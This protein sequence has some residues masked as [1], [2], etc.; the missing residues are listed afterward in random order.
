MSKKP[1][2]FVLMPF[3]AEFGDVYKI[4]IKDGAR[5][6]GFRAERVDTQ[7]YISQTILQRIQSEIANADVIIADMTGKNA[8]VFYEVGYAH[9]LDKPCILITRS[10]DDIPFDL[11]HHKH[12]VYGISLSD[13]RAN[14]V[15]ELQWIKSHLAKQEDAFTL[16]V[17]PHASANWDGSARL[18]EVGKDNAK[19]RVD[20]SIHMSINIY[21]K[22]E[23]DISLNDYI[24]LYSNVDWQWVQ[25]LMPCPVQFSDTSGFRYRTSLFPTSRKIPSETWLRLAIEGKRAYGEF[26]LTRYGLLEIP[27]KGTMLIRIC[28]GGREYDMP[29]AVDLVA[30]DRAS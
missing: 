29:L 28:A 17:E 25:H 14:L 23:T 20:V 30:R 4:A 27:L 3:A 18:I 1:F 15:K 24:Y 11:K 7:K 21:N 8:N 2:A 6:A 5:K 19:A 22:L 9:A 13:L 12:V 10:A 16:N 26:S